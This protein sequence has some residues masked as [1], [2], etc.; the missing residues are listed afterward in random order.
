MHFRFSGFTHPALDAH[1]QVCQEM[2]RNHGATV[3]DRS[4]MAVLQVMNKKVYINI[5]FQPKETPNYSA[6]T[7]I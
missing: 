7:S 3:D 2:P 4:N 5:T 6:V 1:V